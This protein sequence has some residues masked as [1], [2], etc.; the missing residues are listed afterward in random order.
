MNTRHDH[1]QVIA[2]AK[3]GFSERTG[4]R[5]ETE[6]RLP[7]RQSNDRRQPRNTPDPFRGLWEGEIRPML[8]AIPVCAPLPCS[9]RC[10]VVIPSMIGTVCAAA[11]NGAFA[12]GPLTMAPNAR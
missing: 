10:S 7:P 4:R 2:A 6:T 3:A 8:E 11:S 1:S 9:K 12:R 5:I